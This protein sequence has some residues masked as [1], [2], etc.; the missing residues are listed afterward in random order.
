MGTD[1]CKLL[2]GDLLLRPLEKYHKVLTQHYSANSSWDDSSKLHYASLQRTV[3]ASFSET[4]E[5]LH[6]V[7]PKWELT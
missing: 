1:K 6:V 2:F 3:F 7:R 5:K 4:D